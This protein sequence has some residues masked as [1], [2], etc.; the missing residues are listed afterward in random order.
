MKSVPTFEFG[1]EVERI[2]VCRRLFANMGGQDRIRIVEHVP[3]F[4]VFAHEVANCIDLVDRNPGKP[5][6][7]SANRGISKARQAWTYETIGADVL[8]APIPSTLLYML[9][10]TS[11]SFKPLRNRLR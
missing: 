6:K 10:V 1:E 3:L 4:E 9:F 8:G 7:G 2:F 5:R 11:S